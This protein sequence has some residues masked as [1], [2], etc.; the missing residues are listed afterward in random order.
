MGTYDERVLDGYID[1]ALWSSTDDDG[2][3]LDQTYSR[4]DLKSATLNRLRADCA[5]F[6]TRAYDDDLAACESPEQ[7]GHDFWLTRN[8]HGAGFWDR[9]LGDA[10]DRLTALSKWAGEA[11]LYVGD[12]GQLHHE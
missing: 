8:G 5:K 4:A 6:L 10:G 9:D 7:V 1:C 2:E 11:D 12:D 3:P